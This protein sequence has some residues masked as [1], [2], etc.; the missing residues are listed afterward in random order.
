MLDVVQEVAGE[1]GDRERR[2]V[3]APAG[4]LP[5]RDGGEPR[6]ASP[7]RRR[8]SAATSAGS[9][10]PY[11]RDRG[12]VLVP[13]RV[14]RVVGAEHEPEPLVVDA[15]HVADVAAV[16]ERRPDVGRGPRAR[17]AARASAQACASARSRAAMS[18]TA[19]TKPSDRTRGTAARAPR[20]SPW[21]P[22]RHA[23]TRQRQQ[24][25]ARR[26]DLDL[27]AHGR[28]DAAVEAGDPAAVVEL[29][30][31][32][33]L[34]PVRP[35]PLLVQP[36]VEV[37]PGQDLVLAALAGR[38][39]VEVDAERRELA[40]GHRRPALVGEVLAPAVEAAAV[41]PDGLEHP[42]DPAVAA[43]QQAL[44]LPGLAVVVPVADRLADL[45][46]RAD[47]VAEHLQPPVDRLDVGLTGPLERRVRLGHEAADRHR[48]ADVVGAGRLA[49]LADDGVGELG[50]LE[51]VLVGLRR[52]AAH[53]VEL[54]LAPAGGV[55]GRR[56]A[57]EVV[58]ADRLV[59]DPAQPLAAALGREGQA[60]AAS[61][62]GQLLRER[63]VEGVDAG[64]RQRQRGVGALVA[65]G[66]AGGDV[67]DLGVVGAG[68]RQQPDLLVAG[69]L[70][71]GL[72]HLA[73]AGDR[74]LAH[75]PRDHAGLAEAAAPGAAAEDLDAHPLV[76]R[77][78]QRH[79]RLLR[80]RQAVEVHE[81]ALV[82]AERD[83]G[84]VRA[85]RA[86]CGRRAGSRR[87]RSA[88]RRRRRCGRGAAASPR[89]RRRPAWPGGGP[90]S[91]RAR[92]A[93]R[94]RGRRRR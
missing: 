31:L 79:E 34:L 20:S 9:L 36:R 87:R 33:R 28:A 68:Q 41:A 64:G 91:S 16:L 3:A 1:R 25:L 73:D 42:A 18:S 21:C 83:V 6:S 12:G 39:P 65:V 84:P 56:R 37:V 26:P 67:G 8:S 7:P 49:A 88:G 4:P 69:R 53:E 13:V 86:G 55:R 77:L 30:L 14:Q 76:H 48:A 58:L 70:Q 35:E 44:D 78:G 27:G 72:D 11:R 40:G 15:E 93:R 61:A 51:D 10:S 24:L 19:P 47:R 43:G 66:E 80:V 62:A 32:E 59:D 2:A 89:A 22:A 46:V 85:R 81:R 90:A 60:G 50:D 45:A 71:A 5:R 23:T 57:D 82:D 54:H 94:R 74:P 52:E 75:R 29:G 92:P 38:V 63:D 17:P